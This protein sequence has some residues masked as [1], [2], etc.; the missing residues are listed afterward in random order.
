MGQM[1]NLTS[2]DGHSFP[3]YVAQ[4]TGKP[5][6][7]MVIVQE[8]FGLN[9]HIKSVADSY[10][11][12]GYVSIAPAFFERVHK[13]LDIGYTP[14]DIENGRA[15][16]M[17]VDMEKVV[18]DVAA[19]VAHVKG[20]GKVG[21]VGY[22]WG[23]RVA[24]VSAARVDGLA[25]TVSYYGGGVPGLA[26]LKGKVPVMFHWAELDHAIPL[27]TVEAFT[28]AHPEVAATSFIYKGAQHGFNCD[29]RGSYNAEA[30]KIAR[31]RTNEFLLKHLG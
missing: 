14:Q 21:L 18:V 4:P 10:A 8:I 17:K 1:V 9:H 24:W 7:A 25:C 16:M 11:A 2:A 20:H 30:T 5:R 15:I 31:G 13:G 22:C 29:E 27:D 12:D 6:G 19:A 26:S 28:K 23:G 3:A